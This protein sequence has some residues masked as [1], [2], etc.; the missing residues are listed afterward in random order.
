[1]EIT[2]YLNL[3]LFLVIFCFLPL[4]SFAKDY[5]IACYYY[6]SNSGM[7]SKNPSLMRPSRVYAGASSNYY[8]ALN[9]SSDYTKLTGKII[10]GFFIEENLNY[11]NVVQDCNKAIE[12]GTLFW[13]SKK[14]F[15]L[16]DF[17]AATSNF[18]GYEYPIRF[19]KDDTAKSKIKQI[20]VFGDS[21][22][23][24]GN[25]K[26]WLKAM[27]YYPFWFG[28]FSDGFIWN[29]Y[30]SYITQIPVLNF[31]YGGAKTEGFNDYYVKDF[32]EYV[33]NAGRNLV[34]GSSQ[35]YIENYL[36]NYLTA[37]SYQSK[38]YLISKPQENLYII[39]IGANDYI[40][41]FTGE[42]PTEDF[43][44]Y[45]DSVVGSN[46]VYRRAV[47]EIIQQI[48][49]LNQ[50]GAYNFLVLNL[51]DFGKTPIVLDSEYNKYGD[52]L[53][54][55][56]E[57]AEKI[58]EVIKKHNNYL[59]YSI[60]KLQN[61]L[62]NRSNIVYL[63]IGANFN[64]LLDNKN[65][66]DGSNFD[67]GFSLLNSKYPISGDENKFVQKFCYEGGYGGAAKMIAK[68]D[69]KAYE[70]AQNNSCK[71]PDGKINRFAYFWNSPHPTSYM[72]CWI[73]YAI[74]RKLEDNGLIVPQNISI[75]EMKKYC[76]SKVIK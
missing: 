9:P 54:N 20:I 17:K 29:D 46:T 34:T 57:F 31:A 11:N 40:S 36:D 49:L 33:T 67:Y 44:D 14:T 75:D 22:S 72:H 69:K 48:I 42:K 5:Y 28:R 68:S 66:F 3:K 51:P 55:K 74:Q 41:K 71:T 60:D 62:G 25:L 19:L 53:K 21:L 45:P 1:M 73:S 76:S 38:S 2:K 10:D 4:S 24:N 30:V 56:K 13:P 61:I 70:F 6:D 63:D 58:S 50:R 47:D 37:D 18:S 52:D 7:D 26:R 65:I 39:W 12:K 64:S 23:D 43:F 27:P 32:Q 16:Y 8:W 59:K 35:N 15:K